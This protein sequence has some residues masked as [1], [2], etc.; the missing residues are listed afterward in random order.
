MKLVKRF[1]VLVAALVMTLSLAACGGEKYP[2]SYEYKVEW[3]EGVRGELAT[4][5]L[6][7]DGSFTYTYVATDSKDASKEVMN[8]K[9]TGTYTREENIVNVTIVDGECTAMN[10]DTPVDMGEGGYA[11]TYSQGS[12]K[13]ELDGSTFVPVE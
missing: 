6:E 9:V 4:L 7:E 1:V 5:T 13:F 12:T 2:Q 10:G 11:L 3:S 8:C